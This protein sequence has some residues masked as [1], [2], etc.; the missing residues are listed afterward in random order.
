MMPLVK[1]LAHRR[2]NGTWEGALLIQGGIKVMLP[3]E[4]LFPHKLHRYDYSGR[5][6]N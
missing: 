1:S 2:V 4:N 3:R 6:K 5:T